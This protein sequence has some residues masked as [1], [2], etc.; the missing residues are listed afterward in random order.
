MAPKRFV[1]WSHSAEKRPFHSDLSR[2]LSRYQGVH[3]GAPYVDLGLFVFGFP[4]NG[5]L[6]Q[7]QVAQSQ[8]Y[9]SY[10]FIPLALPP[11]QTTDGIIIASV[12]NIGQST[13][14]HDLLLVWEH[15]PDYLTVFNE[16]SWILYR[17]SGTVV[18]AF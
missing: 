15:I 17:D 9:Q 2:F 4:L 16:L 11:E 3:W 14:T 12:R 8:S 18:L 5:N 6:D 10:T 7:C 13:F 1:V